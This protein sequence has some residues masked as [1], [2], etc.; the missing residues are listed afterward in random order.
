M[1]ITTV[2]GIILGTILVI[3]GIIFD[4][5]DPSLF[6]FKNL[7]NFIDLPSIFI[8]LG[9]TLSAV[10]ASYPLNALKQIPKHFK[11]LISGNKYNPMEYIDLLVEFSQVARKNGLLALEEMANKQTE[12]FF[13]QSIMLIV[14]ATDPEK[15]KSMLNN[16][17]DYLAERHSDSVGIYEKASAVAPAFGMIGTLIGLVNML[18]NMNLESGSGGSS[19]LGADMSVALITTFY[20]CVLA[21]LI[22]SPIAKKLSIRNDEEYLCKQIIIEGVLSIQSGENPK[23]MKEKLIS[24]LSQKERELALNGSASNTKENEKNKD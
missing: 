24:Y 8:V 14:D 4:L 6:V 3:F 13:K 7:G 12:P 17:L 16:D 1:D 19:S 2:V 10:I 15:V 11:I 9:G 21:N 5:E 20:G 23:F 22:F 18:K